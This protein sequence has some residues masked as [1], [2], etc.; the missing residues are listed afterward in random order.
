[1][2][3]HGVPHEPNPLLGRDQ[4][5][6]AVASLLRSSRVTSVVGPGGLGKTRLA[7]AVSRRAEQRTVHFV[8]LAGVAADGDVTR[9]VASALGAGASG[10][11]PVGQRPVPTDP[12]GGIVGALGPGPALLVLDNCEHVLRGAADLVHAL[13]SMTQDLRVLTTSRAPLGLSSES[14]YLLPELSLP[15]AVELFEQ[16]ARAARPDAELPAEAVEE[17]CRRL[18]GLPLAV[19]LA[20]ARVRV[21]SV[22]EVARGL[23]DR[24]GLLRGGARDAPER[25]R[26]LQAVVD[27]S[28]NLLEVAG[29]AAMRA[30]AVFP[31]GFTADAARRVL[32]DGDVGDVAKVL[33]HLVDQSLLKVAD[34]PTGARFR[35]LETVREFSTARREA[36]GET[37]P[38]V[39]AFLAWAREF[40]VAHHDAVFGAD[41]FVPL[42]RIR[43]EQDNLAQALR[44]ALARADGGTVAATS[45]V[46][47][48][49]SIIESNYQRMRT[50]ASEAARLLSHFRP[51]PDLVEA[52]RTTLVMFTTYTFLLEGPRA[53]RSLVALRRLP[54]APPDTL[55]RA[56][57]VVL[58]AASED[59]SAL[60]GLAD[61][62]EP[63]VAGAA[64]SV[65]SYFW[66]NESDLDS[67]LKAARRA[68]EAFEQR[69]LSYL[70]AVAHARISELCLQA[71]RGEEARRHLLA[72][73]PV[74]EQVGNRVDLVGIRWWLTLANLQV[75]DVDEA[76]HWLEQTAPPRVDEPVG[77]LTYGLGVRAEILLARGEVEAGLRLW[78]RAVD[79]LVNAEGPIFGLE[80]DPS[81]EQW[82]LE[83]AAVTVVAHA[84]HG[85]LDLVAELTGELPDRLTALLA[86]PVANPPPYLMELPTCGG[87]LLALGM[88]D[89]DRGARTGD[90]RATRSG[91]RLVALAE[92]FRFLRNFQPTMSAAR[93]RQAGQQAD[94]PAYD[95][96]VSSYAGLDDDDLRAAALAALRARAQG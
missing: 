42:A 7:Q 24:F 70:Q 68:L 35:M 71:E 47:G 84:Q 78:R 33:E 10:R 64:N 67:A 45:A 22:A 83:A 28:W 36:A 14:V 74:L 88:V 53:V 66:E 5:V 31:G 81:Q 11:A 57:A 51:G 95:E 37:G 46:L 89:L 23:E 55:V 2:V 90:E 15:T 17:V 65:V 40:G 43:A 50:L 3:R 60:Y 20:A 1:V 96:A 94:R 26:T 54:P 75:G 21:M 27:W 69:E 85:R 30:L 76:E 25:H 86:N 61:S 9:E 44:Y 29:Q 58:G 34:T 92:R 32:G 48:N 79:L 91:A 87:L 59:R 18:D 63:L 56:V 49:L 6:A 62:D 72:A 73:L 12:L 13:V 38:V 93:A 4:D 19:E 8:A 16:R 41:P 77:S 39:G 52:T 82:V 80:V